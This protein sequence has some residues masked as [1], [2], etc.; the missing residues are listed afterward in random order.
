MIC[1]LV[2]LC[3]QNNY[4]VDVHW[5]DDSCVDST[6]HSGNRGMR[7]RISAYPSSKKQAG[8]IKVHTNHHIQNLKNMAY[9]FHQFSKGHKISKAN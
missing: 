9:V 5:G 8:G 7:S 3:C 4:I 6:V 1:E 2:C